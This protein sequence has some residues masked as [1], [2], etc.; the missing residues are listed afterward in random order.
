MIILRKCKGCDLELPLDRYH[1]QASRLDGLRAKC[2]TCR[3]IEKEEWRK[4][5]PDKVKEQN[6]KDNSKKVTSGKKKEYY[7]NNREKILESSKRTYYKSGQAAQLAWQRSDP[8]R[9]R[10]YN[11]KRR[12]VKLQAIPPWFDKEEV[13]YIYRLAK[14]R[15]LVVDHIVPLN[16]PHVCGL[17]VQ[18]N[19]RCISADLNA[20]KGNRYWP[21]M[22]TY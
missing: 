11:A 10:A 16:S 3:N 7:W 22:W 2:I 19:L 17:H 12:A 1:K 8:A 14:E 21:D 18:N 15:G 13:A 5:N 20:R 6:R 9:Q 4:K